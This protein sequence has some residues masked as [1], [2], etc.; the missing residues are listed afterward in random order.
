MEDELVHLDLQDLLDLLGHL[1]Q[2]EVR[3]LGVHLEEM[4]YL[5]HPDLRDPGELQV[6]N[7]QL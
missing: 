5:V 1:V 2:L 3:D 6:T 7:L 4:V